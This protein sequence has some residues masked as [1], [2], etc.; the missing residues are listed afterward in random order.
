MR[1]AGKEEGARGDDIGDREVLDAHRM[2]TAKRRRLIL[3]FV[4]QPP[5]QSPSSPQL[6]SSF[7]T[8]TSLQPHLILPRTCS[9]RTAMGHVSCVLCRSR[10]PE[11]GAHLFCLLFP[12]PPNAR[13]VLGEQ[14]PF[15]SAQISIQL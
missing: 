2:R 14:A 3:S 9:I 6:P 13:I 7:P 4:L 12:Q 8:A 10:P 5:R 11:A 15:S 1:K